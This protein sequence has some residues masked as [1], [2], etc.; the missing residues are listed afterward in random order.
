MKMAAAGD[1]SVTIE[2][3]N[4]PREAA[5]DLCEIVTGTARL[6]LPCMAHNI[7]ST[8]AML[9]TGS[10]EIP[11][12]FI[13]ANHTRHFRAVCKVVW[14]TGRMI[15]VAFATPPRDTII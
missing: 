15:G 2:N 14:R 12:R 4:S 9:E 8:G 1:N 5:Q 13:L 6:A 3:R 7:S 11:D 10:G